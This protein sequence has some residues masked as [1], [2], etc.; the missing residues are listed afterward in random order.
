MMYRR[1]ILSSFPIGE[2]SECSETP[3]I[4]RCLAKTAFCSTNICTWHNVWS[5]EFG[6]NIFKRNE[7]VKRRLK[8]SA[9]IYIRKAKRKSQN[10][11]NLVIWRT[12]KYQ[13]IVG[14]FI[15]VLRALS[16]KAIKHAL[17]HCPLILKRQYFVNK[18]SSSF[19]TVIQTW[20]LSRL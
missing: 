17:C 15:R 14:V 4:S 5:Q 2:I 20:I 13:K 6:N 9:K 8:H 11:Q 1:N 12:E 3:I 10:L 7:T 19:V 16:F 18:I